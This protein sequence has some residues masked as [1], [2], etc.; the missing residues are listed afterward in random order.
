MIVTVTP[1]GS[2]DTILRRVGPPGEEEQQVLPVAQTA[3]GK[4]HNVARFLVAAGVGAT[5]CGFAGGWVGREMEALLQEAGVQSRLTPIAA[6]SRRYVTC[7][8]EGLPRRSLHSPGPVVT[9]AEC[10]RLVA[11]VVAAAGGASGVVLAGSLPPG[12][13]AHLYATIV[14]EVAPVPVIL[15][16]SGAPLVAGVAA[17]PR[18]VKVNASEIG[19]LWEAPGGEPA[20]SALEGPLAG[21]ADAE[22]WQP[23]LA[24]LAERSGVD[25][26]WVTLGPSG[27]VGWL[28]GDIV[29]VDA[30]PVTTVNTTGAGDAFLAGLLLAGLEDADIHE[31]AIRATAMAAALCEQEVTLPPDP[32]RV[33]ALRPG[34]RVR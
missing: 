23:V 12:A 28:R 33:A 1:N 24:R 21:T 15:D 30:P 5:A 17:R 22:A 32:G 29:A 4:G 16:T 9:D 31:A 11:D 14:G 7:L 26:W 10:R 27:A 3:G 2:V 25:A 6:S 34:V 13:P 19:V 20:L 8:G 18:M